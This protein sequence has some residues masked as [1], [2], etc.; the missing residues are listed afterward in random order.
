MAVMIVVMIVCMNIDMR[1]NDDCM[2]M[3]TTTMSVMNRMDGDADPHAD[4]DLL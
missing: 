3:M 4:M 2:A 1:S